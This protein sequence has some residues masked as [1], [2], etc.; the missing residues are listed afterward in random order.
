M[1]NAHLRDKNLSFKA[2]GLLSMMLSLPD[3]WD[4]SI[5][6]ISSISKESTSAIKSTLNELKEQGYLIVTKKL[7]NETESGRI[8]YI[9]DIYETKQEGKKQGVENQPLEFLPLEV[10][11][12]ENQRQINTNILNTKEIN[13]KELNTYININVE[14][15]ELWRKYPKKQGKKEAFNHYK[16][17]R[18][19]ASFEEIEKGL[20][21][22]LMYIKSN[23]IELRYIKNGSTWFNGHYEDEYEMPR[24][25]SYDSEAVKQKAQ[26][27]IVYK[28]NKE[29]EV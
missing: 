26:Q 20:N 22:Y 9:Y 21:N 16:A 17:T 6:G 5:E 29:R 12:L 18:K 7:P 23:N 28:R 15:E 3:N 25:T 4:Y 14:F 10:Q 2:K 24:E 1:S 19:K 11:P 27:E 8:E 13:T